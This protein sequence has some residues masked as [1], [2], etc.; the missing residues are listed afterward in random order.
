M[1]LLFTQLHTNSMFLPFVNNGDPD[2][3]LEVNYY[4]EN[5]GDPGSL[6]KVIDLSAKN[7]YEGEEGE[8]SIS[9]EQYALCVLRMKVVNHCHQFIF[10]WFEIIK[11]SKKELKVFLFSI[12]PNQFEDYFSSIPSLQ[13]DLHIHLSTELTLGLVKQTQQ[14]H[15][16]APELLLEPAQDLMVAMDFKMISLRTDMAKIGSSPMDLWIEQLVKFRITGLRRLVALENGIH[17]E[18]N[19]HLAKIQLQK[20]ISELVRSFQSPNNTDGDLQKFFR[21][22]AQLAE[23]LAP[24]MMLH[25]IGVEIQKRS[26]KSQVS[27]WESVNSTRAYYDGDKLSSLATLYQVGRTL[28]MESW[29]ENLFFPAF[30]EP[31][32]LDFEEIKNLHRTLLFHTS[33]P[34][35]WNE[36]ARDLATQQ[37]DCNQLELLTS[38]GGKSKKRTMIQGVKML[39]HLSHRVRLRL[40]VESCS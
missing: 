21:H 40:M 36:L 9:E 34:S 27:A 15:Q 12:S 3:C 13:D 6:K 8:D 24:K 10:K 5:Y 20:F 16:I 32:L 18:A 11:S 31:P 22:R 2:S 23:S 30:N 1:E 38:T 37:T 28:E 35:L 4:C 25:A 17:V 26:V 19:T 7:D 14:R 39:M 29:F 33:Q